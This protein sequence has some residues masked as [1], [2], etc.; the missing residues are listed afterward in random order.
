MEA[1]EVELAVFFFFLLPLIA[2]AFLAATSALVWSVG[3]LTE[4]RS[5]IG[6]TIRVKGELT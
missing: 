4:K 5:L 6:E 1:R 3:V 2:A